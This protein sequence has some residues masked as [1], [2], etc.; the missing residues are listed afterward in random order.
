MS[1]EDAVIGTRTCVTRDFFLACGVVS[2]QLLLYSSECFAL[3]AQ[4]RNIGKPLTLCRTWF[5]VAGCVRA[6]ARVRRNCNRR[7]QDPGEKERSGINRLRCYSSQVLASIGV[8]V[9]VGCESGCRSCNFVALRYPG[10]STFLDQRACVADPIIDAVQFFFV[11]S[12]CFLNST[13][14]VPSPAA[15]PF[16]VC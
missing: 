13:L 9:M 12:R 10:F 1:E 2:L 7:S 11:F 8:V 3:G 5:R 6:Q 16:C 14:L 15:L 4:A